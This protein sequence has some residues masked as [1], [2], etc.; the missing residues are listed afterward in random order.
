MRENLSQSPNPQQRAFMREIFTR[1]V[2]VFSIF[3]FLPGLR[4]FSG[5]PISN[6]PHLAVAEHAI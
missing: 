1:V 5:L 6:V 2:D 3:L 4:V